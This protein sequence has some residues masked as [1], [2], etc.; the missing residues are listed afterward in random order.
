MSLAVVHLMLHRFV[1][2]FVFPRSGAPR[3]QAVKVV[4]N[5]D[6]PNREEAGGLLGRKKAARRVDKEKPFRW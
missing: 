2:V 5:F 4:V 3:S 6:P 1:A